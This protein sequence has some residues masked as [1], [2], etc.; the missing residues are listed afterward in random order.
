MDHLTGEIDSIVDAF[1]EVHSQKTLV[2]DPG[3]MFNDTGV[4]ALFLYRT[5]VDRRQFY[6]IAVDDR[7]IGDHHFGLPCAFQHQPIGNLAVEDH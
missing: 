7:A 2:G 5:D 4:K 6:D 1:K 3:L